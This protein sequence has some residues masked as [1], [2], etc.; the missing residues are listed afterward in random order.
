MLILRGLRS[1]KPWL[2]NIHL[3]WSVLCARFRLNSSCKQPGGLLVWVRP[4]KR[5]MV[6]LYLS[7]TPL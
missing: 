5:V 3:N 1:C 7:D 4:D 6:A 2:K